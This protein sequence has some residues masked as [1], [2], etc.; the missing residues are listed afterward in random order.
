MCIKTFLAAGAAALAFG[1]AP[2]VPAHA[3]DL[4]GEAYRLGSAA[5]P[6]S[7]QPA[8]PR[9]YP[10]LNSGYWR[11]TEEMRGSSRYRNKLPRYHQAWGW[12]SRQWY[13]AHKRDERRHW[14]R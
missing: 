6:Y 5:D 13:I 2:S 10:Y 11:P 4:R 1:L 12:N 3:F 14:E 7:Y 8:H 9:Y